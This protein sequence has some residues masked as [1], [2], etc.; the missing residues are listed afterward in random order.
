MKL[1]KLIQKLIASLLLTIIVINNLEGLKIVTDAITINSKDGDNLHLGLSAVG[2]GIGYGIDMTSSG[3]EGK[4]IWNIKSYETASASSNSVVTSN[5][6]CI[7]AG[8]GYTWENLKQPNAVLTYDQSTF[9]ENAVDGY[10]NE[11]LWII[12]HMYIPQE[13]NKEKFL[14]SIGIELYEDAEYKLYYYN[15]DLTPEYDYTDLSS[16]NE[17]AYTLTDDDIVA[18]QQAVIWYYTNYKVNPSTYGIYNK[19]GK[20]SSW[21]KYTTNG[22]NYSELS[23]LNRTSGEGPA[24]NEFATILYNYLIDAATKEVAKAGGT[25]KLKNNTVKLWTATT[26]G[27]QE[28]P[29]IEVHKKQKIGEYDLILV[30]EDENGEQL[31]STATFIV[32]DVEKVVTGKL[33][34]ASKVQITESNLNRTDTYIIKEKIPPDE[35][36]EFNGIIMVSVTK[37]ETADGYEVDQVTYVVRDE[38]GNDITQEIGDTVKVYL[39]DGNI[40]VKVK[41]YPEEKAFDLALR[42]VI[43]QVKD[44]EGNIKR[45]VDANGNSATRNV[46]V[47]TSTLNNEDDN[48]NT[49]T[50]TYRHRKDPVLVEKGDKVKYTITIYNE[51]EEAGYARKIVD[52]LPGTW[53]AGLRLLS[54]ADVTSTTGNVYAVEYSTTTNKVTFT[55]KSTSPRE[56]PAYNGKTL[57]KETIEL[58]CEVMATADRSQNMTLTNIA[59]IAEEYNSKT[60]QVITIEGDRD[61]QPSKYPTYNGENDITQ[62]GITYGEDIGYK[63]HKS[64]SSIL[65]QNDTYYKGEEDD[66]DFEKVVILPEAKEFDLALRK[67]ITEIEET[68]VNEN[69]KPNEEITKTKVTSRIPEV[70]YNKETN[71]ITYTHS[72]APL[73]V[74]VGDTVI[75]TIRVYNEGDIAGYATEIT[76]DIPEYLE[77]LPEHETNEKYEWKMYDKEGKETK[78]VRKAVKIKTTHLAKGEGEEKGAILGSSKYTANL[79]KAF[80]PKAGIS[81]TNPDYRDIKVAFKVKDPSSSEYVITNFVE[82]SEDSDEYGDP[83]KDKDS[84]PGNGEGYPKEDDEDIEN[85]RVEYFDLAL[86]KYVTKAIVTEEG[87]ETVI[88]TGNIGDENDIIPKVEINRKKIKQTVVKFA[89]TIKITNEGN[90]AGYATEITDYIPEGLEFK[91]ED[92]ENWEDEGNRVISTRQLEKVLLQP[93]QSAEVEVVL[94]WVN[95][96]NNLGLKR[97]TAEISEDY[98]EKGIPDRDSTPDNQK[99]GEDDIDNAEVILSIKTGGEVNRI[100][101]SLGIVVLLIISTGIVLI[102]KYV[103]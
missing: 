11:I 59:Y 15:P 98:N 40:Y 10:Y 42:K 78:D 55:L 63:G 79:I 39:K 95:E 96:E 97:N 2:N 94:R 62:D 54:T 28:Q 71:Q 24:R 25:Y 31:N 87:K 32:N 77:Y 57:S 41:N 46:T 34:V 36:C 1:Q 72:K 26:Y 56:I 37:K 9:N 101:Y 29:I 20:N 21:L 80:N 52:Q 75:Y 93:G 22:T 90:I 45:I 60:N 82:I 17:Y 43:T 14:K 92:N 7:K 88:E 4:Y 23:S 19:L 49:D 70:S 58:E 3:T 99:E 33:T 53:G 100:Y 51:G 66:D 61:S 6:Y 65:S 35:Y 47:D 30:K 50:A 102:K 13:D 5:L 89:Y 83:I 67:F 91:K 8:F 48:R 44:A 84:I 86:L 64:N 16:G 69:K 27:N 103:I 85:I 81:G 74:H 12:D 68:G 76:D 73:V 18:V 38:E